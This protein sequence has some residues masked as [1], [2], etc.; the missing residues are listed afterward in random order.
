MGVVLQYYLFVVFSEQIRCFIGPQSVDKSPSQALKRLRSDISPPSSHDPRLCQSQPEMFTGH[1]E[2][3]SY[4]SSGDKEP[5]QFCF[6]QPAQIDDLLVSTQQYLATQSNNS[7]VRVSI[8]LPH[9]L[10]RKSCD[11]TLVREVWC[12]G[13]Q[14][15][16]KNITVQLG[17]QVQLHAAYCTRLVIVLEFLQHHQF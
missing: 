1:H 16:S 7:Q 15:L 3:A 10:S 2:H 8:S 17:P 4:A 14:W 6:S 9:V 5:P 12:G 13:N 11:I